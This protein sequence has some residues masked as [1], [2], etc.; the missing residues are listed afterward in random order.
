LRLSAWAPARAATDQAIGYF[1]ASGD[2]GS[3][4]IAGTTS[5][6]AAAQTYTMVG[7]GTNMWATRDEFQF[8]W[9]KLSGDFILRTHAAFSGQGVEEHRKL[10]WIIRT[11]LDADATYVDAAIHGNGLTSLQ[12]RAVKGG[13]TMQ[14]PSAVVAPDVIQLERKGKMFIMSVA[15]YG[16]PF[17]RTEL[18]EL[19]LGSDGLRRASSS[20]RTTPRCPER[21]VFSNVRIVVPP[22]AG[23]RPYRDYIGSN[24]EVMKIGSPALK[25]LYTAPGS[26]QAPNWTRDG[27]SLIYNADGKLYR[28][29]LGTKTPTLIDTG[30][31]TR[32]NNDHV[33]SFAGDMLGISSS[34]GDSDGS[35]VLRCRTTGWRAEAHHESLAVLLPRLVA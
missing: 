35:V 20:A 19:D 14:L 6:D 3:P 5:Y 30:T 4:A 9:R 32:N 2:V 7:S 26:F 17:T 28:F 18:T 31:V 15:R 12:Y 11:S 10:G 22:P 34:A 29:D 27:K 13:P 16:E 25:V 24:L 8:A 23:W 33:L 1:D 21:A